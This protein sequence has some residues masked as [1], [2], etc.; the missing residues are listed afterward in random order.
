VSKTK[1]VWQSKRSA[2]NSAPRTDTRRQLGIHAAIVWITIWTSAVCS[3]VPIVTETASEISL[4]NG[5]IAVK[6]NKSSGRMT[7]LRFER[8]DF[9]SASGTRG[10]YSANIRPIGSGGGS[11]WEMGLGGLETSY[12]VGPDFVDVALFHPANSSMPYDVTQHYV[13]RDGESG[14]HVYSNVHHTTEMT[15]QQIEEM[16]F[17]L[18]ADPDV[19]T[20]HWITPTRH[21]I[22]PTPAELSA[23]TTLA[24]ATDR[25]QDGTAYEAETGKD[26]YTKYDYSIGMDEVD[27]F[28]Y[29]GDDYGIWLVQP[30]RE[31]LLGGPTKQELTIHQTTSTPVLLGM[32]V[33]QHYGAS[34]YVA[35]PGD[36]DRQYG[37]FYVHVNSGP[38]PEAMYA[39]ALTYYDPDYH[40]SFYDSLGMSGWVDSADR[41]NVQGT[42][43]FASGV[44]AEG[45]VVILADNN[46]DFQF[47]KYGYQYWT[48]VGPDGAFD[49]EGVRPGTYRVTAY[50][51]DTYGKYQLDDV[52]VGSGGSVDLGNISWQPPD[53]GADLWQIGTFDRTATEFRY[54]AD[55][56]YR[57]YEM[58]TR[59]A[60][61]FPDDVNFV[62]GESNEATDWNF[63]H[64]EH[65]DGQSSPVW[66]ILFD[67]GELP[68]DRT[69]TLTI[70]VAGQ[71]NANLRVRVNGTIVENNWDL[72]YNGAVLHRSGMQAVYQSRVIHFSTSLL[73][74]G[75]NT[76]SLSHASPGS[77]DTDGIIYDALR[78]EI[79]I[80]AGDYNN[81][82]IINAA[83]YTVW[84]D[85][86]G[87]DNP[88][89]NDLLGGTIGGQQYEQW[90]N[91]F[92]LSSAGIA[93]AQVPEP[94]GTVLIVCGILIL[95]C[96]R[97][98]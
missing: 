8:A 41:S 42:F 69:A 34:G 77:S 11:Y 6:V 80:L 20:H 24:D 89:P 13:L 50:A 17:V 14:F 18:R 23:G 97:Q 33:G 31:T 81:D 61:D 93:A 38:S 76:I 54:G 36:F 91:N 70:A 74:N 96:G 65:V 75:T 88:L 3:A 85:N 84:R 2:R 27:V 1:V 22:M 63:A 92:G 37:P 58:W 78:L 25:L 79:D 94:A 49:L 21:N 30:N 5:E 51:P 39:D 83:D 62:I 64:W 16:R 56:E 68:D 46:T 32:L 73:V 29:Y 7:S 52:T 71:E 82:G 28:G 47:S 10:Y 15:P 40:R 86:F 48:R 26:V 44:P 87:T 43:R 60:D 57:Q 95:C 53:W 9:L 4:G 67:T 72:P 55:D 12:T 59:Y 66:D 98:H 90:K 19:F 45:A 35:A